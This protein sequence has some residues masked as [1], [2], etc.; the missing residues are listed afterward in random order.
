MPL[1][2]EKSIRRRQS[3]SEEA[4]ALAM[5][6]RWPEAIEVNRAIL[7]EFP[8]DVDAYNRLGR[9]YM[10][11][12]E[13]TQAREAYSHTLEIDPYNA[14]ARKNLQRLSYLKENKTASGVESR[15]V[16]PENFIEEMGKAGVVGLYSLAPKEVL[17]GTVAGDSAYLKAE[18][19]RLVVT[20]KSGEYLGQVSPKHTQRLIK[21][22]EGGNKYSAAIV[23]LTDESLDVMIRE[24]YQDPSQ[25]GRLSFPPR[26]LEEVRPYV[27]DRVLKLEAEQEEETDDSGYTIIGGD[28]IEVLSEKSDDIDED[29]E[30]DED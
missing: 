24:V 26:G 3:R 17:A 19:S 16:E 6:G 30:S 13:Y 1:E 18:G 7:E 29:N 20:N 27:G 25:A 22:M 2:D 8:G 12:G 23:R 9:A 21:L 10:E 15:R 28:E 11:Q 14:I 5:E 4:I